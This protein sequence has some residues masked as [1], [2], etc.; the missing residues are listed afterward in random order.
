[1]LS[2]IY[3]KKRKILHIFLRK[4]C[5]KFE[6]GVWWILL[7][8]EKQRTEYNVFCKKYLKKII[9]RGIIKILY[10]LRKE[11]TSYAY[12]AGNKRHS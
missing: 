7:K 12:K 2:Y 8:K 4:Y 9:N 11:N 3:D 10:I 5:T 6:G 1:M